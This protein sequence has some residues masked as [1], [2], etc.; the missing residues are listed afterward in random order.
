MMS[1]EILGLRATPPDVA[2]E[3][4]GVAG[5]IATAVVRQPFD[6]DRQAIDSAEPTLDR[7]HHQVAHPR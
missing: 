5:N 6:G 4:A 3:A 2:S 1:E 7:R